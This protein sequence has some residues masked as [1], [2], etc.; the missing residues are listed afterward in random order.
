MASFFD[1]VEKKINKTI[2]VTALINIDKKKINILNCVIKN[3]QL[4]RYA[5]FY[6]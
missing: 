5:M 1:R 6:V 3:I 4:D 2:Q